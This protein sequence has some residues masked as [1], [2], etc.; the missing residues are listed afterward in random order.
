MIPTPPNFIFQRP[1]IPIKHPTFKKE[2]CHKKREDVSENEKESS[3]F[4]I[5]KRWQMIKKNHEN[6]QYATYVIYI[7]FTF[8]KFFTFHI[9]LSVLF[10]KLILFKSMRN[11]TQYSFQISNPQQSLSVHI[12]EP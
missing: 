1:V 12:Y 10:Y 8:S 6:N 3:K 2:P 4:N 5:T 11:L 9:N 7:C